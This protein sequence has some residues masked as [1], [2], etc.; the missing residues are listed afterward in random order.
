MPRQLLFQRDTSLRSA[1]WCMT[2]RRRDKA[3]E[4]TLIK[5]HEHGGTQRNPGDVIDLADDIAHWLCEIGSAEPV[6]NA[7][8]PS[9]QPNIT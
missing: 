5:P 6:V 7:A 3:M 1:P 9:K 4:V 8:K 2:S